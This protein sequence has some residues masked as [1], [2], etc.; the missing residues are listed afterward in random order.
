MSR[1]VFVYNADMRKLLLVVFIIALGV[2]FLI[3]PG[4]P[5]KLV[6]QKKTWESVKGIETTAK[7]VAKKQSLNLLSQ[8]KSTVQKGAATVV[9]TINN[10]LNQQTQQIL[11]SVF[12]ESS[13]TP[14]AVATST[15]IPTDPKSL[16]VV[17][18]LTGKNTTLHFL[19]N[20][21]Y[22]LDLHNVPENFC[23]YINTSKYTL[24][25]KKYV[26]ISF[27]SQGNYQIAF[28]YCSEDQ[29]KF[30]EIVVE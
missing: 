17:D 6:V 2:F 30:G 3:R 22:F 12:N 16:V 10:T 19:R 21:T 14:P 4:T 13:T 29:K 15:T 5:S 27:P 28:D 7:K 1:S 8:A 25:P 18:F 24:E 11:N 20:Q 23:L 9:S 26:T